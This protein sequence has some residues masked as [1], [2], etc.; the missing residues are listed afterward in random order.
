MATIKRMMTQAEFAREHG[1]SPAFV[2]KLK[3]ENRLV[4]N[5]QRTLVDA[6]AST[7]LIRKTESPEHS[8]L[9]EKHAADRQRKAEG[10]GGTAAVSEKRIPKS[11]E[12]P[13]YWISKARHQSA[14]ADLAELELQQQRKELVNRERVVTV[15]FLI[16]R[17][18]RDAMLGMPAR[19]SPEFAAMTSAFEIEKKFTEEI[20]IVLTDLSKLSI[21][22]LSKALER[23]D[24]K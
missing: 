11:Q 3:K 19:L 12:D 1:W 21:D 10:K 9:K 17:M 20:R 24:A 8:D 13:T 23:D 18:M 4:M 5:K 2:S 14:M 7:E 22:D 6:D 15:S 16:G